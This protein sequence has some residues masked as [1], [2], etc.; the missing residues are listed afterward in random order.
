MSTSRSGPRSARFSAAMT[1]RFDELDTIR[2]AVAPQVGGVHVD[3]HHHRRGAN[4]GI[5]AAD[6]AHTNAAGHAV[7]SAAIVRALA[8][9]LGAHSTRR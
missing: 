5:F 8:A 3:T 9:R 7:A 4:P 6:L 2:A 1:E